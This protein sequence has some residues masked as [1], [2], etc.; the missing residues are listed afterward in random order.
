MISFDNKL[1]DLCNELIIT[2]ILCPSSVSPPIS[3][4]M[5]SSFLFY[6]KTQYHV[7]VLDPQLCNSCLRGNNLNVSSNTC[8]LLFDKKLDYLDCFVGSLFLSNQTDHTIIVTEIRDLSL[9]GTQQFY[10]YI[11]LKYSAVNRRTKIVGYV[12]VLWTNNMQDFYTY[13]A[14][15]KIEFSSLSYIKKYE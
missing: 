6:S 10:C 5:R 7:D 14:C 9:Y 12:S 4:R 2:L 3:C 13:V 11:L 1:I 15:R 8:P